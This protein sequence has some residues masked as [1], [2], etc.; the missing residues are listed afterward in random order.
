MQERMAQEPWVPTRRPMVFAAGGVVALWGLVES[1][2]QKLALETMASAMPGCRGLDS[3][4]VAVP[5][6]AGAIV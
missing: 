3:H 5:G 1:E 2:S 6:I 4:L